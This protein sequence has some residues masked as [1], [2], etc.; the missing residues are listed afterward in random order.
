MSATVPLVKVLISFLEQSLTEPISHR[1]ACGDRCR[2]QIWQFHSGFHCRDGTPSGH[3]FSSVVSSS[4]SLCLRFTVPQLSDVY[5]ILSFSFSWD[6]T[7]VSGSTPD[8]LNQNL[9]F[10]KFPQVICMHIK[11]LK[12]PFGTCWKG[13]FCARLLSCR[14]GSCHWY[15][16]MILKLFFDPRDSAPK[17]IPR[18][19]FS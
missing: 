14:S 17:L 10:S 3:Y 4:R 2:P 12:V 18:N 11:M 7:R 13:V 1:A 6:L 19:N 15:W 9:H 8:P 5:R 16:G